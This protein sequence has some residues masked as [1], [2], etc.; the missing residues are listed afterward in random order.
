MAIPWPDRKEATNLGDVED[1]LLKLVFGELRGRIYTVPRTAM[2]ASS[3]TNAMTP[4]TFGPRRP[5]ISPRRRRPYSGNVMIRHRDGS[6]HRRILLL[7]PRRTETGHR[8]SC[9]TPVWRAGCSDEEGQGRFVSFSTAKTATPNRSPCS[10]RSSNTG[11]RIWII[12]RATPIAAYFRAARK[13]ELV[14]LLKQTDAFF[15]REKPLGRSPLAR[16]AESTP[17]NELFERR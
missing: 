11:R 15:P 10:S 9:L 6:I 12:R 16:L 8:G 7:G 4:N 13:A 17:Q 2:P 3:I 14:A 1:R 5:R